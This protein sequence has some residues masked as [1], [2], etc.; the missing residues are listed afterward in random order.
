MV[1]STVPEELRCRPFAVEEARQFGL[2]WESLQAKSWRRMSRGQY[3]WVALRHDI[4]LRLQAVD[5]RLPARSAFSGQTAAWIQGRDVSPC[6]PI[7]VTVPR[8]LPV[9]AR[10]GVRLRRAS[11]PESDITICRGFRVT[12]TLRTTCDLGSRRD[13]TESTVAIDMATHAGVTDLKSINRYVDENP[14][15]KGIRRLRRALALADPRSE[16][17]METRLR[18]ELVKARLPKPAVQEELYDEHGQFLARADLYYSDVRLAIEFDGQDHKDRLGPDLRR[19]NALLNAGYRIV[20]F[21]AADLRVRGAAASQ[22]RRIRD[23]L[24]RPR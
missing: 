20:R 14:G 17:P 15:S 21:T 23:E 1:W 10:A 12:T 6:D 7:E 2:T 5:L 24:L 8:D 11:L 13:L 9:R 18:L 19:Q 4:E 22:V 3:V 16:S